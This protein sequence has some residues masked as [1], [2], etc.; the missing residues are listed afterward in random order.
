MP[1]E[2]RHNL[3]YIYKTLFLNSYRFK[4]FF[5]YII[6]F[7]DLSTIPYFRRS[8]LRHQDKNE[9]L[10]IHIFLYPY[11]ELHQT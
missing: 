11:Q 4:H 9:C 3:I 1:F 10:Q 6:D 5:I 7:Y 2:K 8:I